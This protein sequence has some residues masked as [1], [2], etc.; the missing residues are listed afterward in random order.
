MQGCVIV[1]LLRTMHAQDQQKQALQSQFRKNCRR[2][3]ISSFVY[4]CSVVCTQINDYIVLVDA[5]P[6]VHTY[7]D[8]HSRTYERSDIQPTIKVIAIEKLW[9]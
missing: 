8:T 5:Q 4:M 6:L 1:R 3:L 9:L 7:L 2:Q